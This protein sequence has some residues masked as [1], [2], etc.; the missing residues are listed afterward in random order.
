MEIDLGK[1]L[2]ELVSRVVQVTHNI[3]S[4]HI[5]DRDVGP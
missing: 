5:G 4:G 3:S 1:E 2:L